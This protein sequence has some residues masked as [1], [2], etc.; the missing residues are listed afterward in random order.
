ME[1]IAIEI[2]RSQGASA[3]HLRGVWTPF[4]NQPSFTRTQTERLRLPSRIPLDAT[5]MARI[6]GAV[7]AEMVD[8]EAAPDMQRMPEWPSLFSVIDGDQPQAQEAP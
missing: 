8:W 4:G 7:M 1:R 2:W 6:I 3:L 5:A